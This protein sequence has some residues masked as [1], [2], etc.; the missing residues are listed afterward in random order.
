MHRLARRLPNASEIIE[1]CESGMNMDFDD[2]TEKEILPVVD[3]PA[4]KL[5]EL[6]AGKDESKFLPW[7][8]KGLGR[9]IL[10]LEDLNSAEATA[11]VLKLENAKQ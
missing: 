4:E 8:S 9:E 3:N 7:L 5:I 1:M 10:K 11:T 2:R 6:M